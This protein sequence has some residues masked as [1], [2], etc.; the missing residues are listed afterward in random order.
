MVN[1]TS[2]EAPHLMVDIETLGTSAN[3][4]IVSIGACVFSMDG[5]IDSAQWNV[6]QAKETPGEIDEST[7]LWWIKQSEEAKQNTFNQTKALSLDEALSNLSDMFVEHDFA[8]IWGNGVTFDII[9]LQNMF[10]AVSRT[11]PWSFTQVRCMRSLRELTEVAIAQ[12]E[13]V[14]EVWRHWLH[15]VQETE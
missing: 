2:F 7:T 1:T 9:I 5:V 11:V 3:A 12:A 6:I 15:L 10:N 14:I 8:T 13:T 4:R